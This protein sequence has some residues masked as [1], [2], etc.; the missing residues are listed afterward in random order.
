[1]PVSVCL[2]AH[3]LCSL[4]LAFCMR[5]MLILTVCIKNTQGKCVFQCFQ[6]NFSYLM[7][8]THEIAGG[9]HGAVHEPQIISD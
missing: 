5:T 2:C 3:A 9:I 1:M 7:L 8:W 6:I 4:R